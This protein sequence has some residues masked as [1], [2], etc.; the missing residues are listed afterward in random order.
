MT[1]EE[2]LSTY[3]SEISSIIRRQMRHNKRLEFE[4]LWQ[5]AALSLW[6]EFPRIVQADNPLGYVK[7]NVARCVK[8]VI[9]NFKRDALF[10]A[11]SLNQLEGYDIDIDEE[12]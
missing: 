9:D 4:D 5:E 12:G 7:R 2:L 11:T 6:A 1:F 10:N 3:K 8:R